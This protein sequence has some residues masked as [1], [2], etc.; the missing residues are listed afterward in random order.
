MINKKL[1]RK[2]LEAEFHEVLKEVEEIDEILGNEILKGQGITNLFY[3][4]DTR[5][6]DNLE[7][8]K[9]EFD[10]PTKSD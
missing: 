4:R 9:N 2:K 8:F 5:V 3:K 10:K 1:N 6:G 7:R